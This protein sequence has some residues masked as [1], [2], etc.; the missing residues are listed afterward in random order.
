MSR[1]EKEVGVRY[2]HIVRSKGGREK[3]LSTFPTGRLKRKKGRRTTGLGPTDCPN[4]LE[5]GWANGIREK[6]EGPYR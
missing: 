5:K 3:N 6:A 1:M 4:S 2:G